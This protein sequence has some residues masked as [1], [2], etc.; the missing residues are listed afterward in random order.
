LQVFVI[1]YERSAVKKNIAFKYNAWIWMH[2]YIS[3][4]KQ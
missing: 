3:K 1:T 4:F 2:R